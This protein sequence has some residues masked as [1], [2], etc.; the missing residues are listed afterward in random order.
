[1]LYQ[2]QTRIKTKKSLAY[3]TLGIFKRKDKTTQ[4]ILSFIQIKKYVTQRVTI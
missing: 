4:E 1:M 3:E 2:R